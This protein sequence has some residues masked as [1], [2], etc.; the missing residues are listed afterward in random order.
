MKAEKKWRTIIRWLRDARISLGLFTFSVAVLVLAIF[1]VA[2]SIE[3]LMADYSAMASAQS[4]IGALATTRNAVEARGNALR[5]Y[6]ITGNENLLVDYRNTGSDSIASLANLKGLV[7]GDIA[8]TNRTEALQRTLAMQSAVME[9]I[10]DAYQHRRVEHVRQLLIEDDTKLRTLDHARRAIL[11]FDMAEHATLST[12]TARSNATLRS[13]ILAGTMGL[14]LYFLV[15]CTVFARMDKESEGRRGADSL[16]V[17]TNTELE[18]SL[19]QLK[20]HNHVAQ[21]VSQFGEILQ[22]C[23]SVGEATALTLHQVVHFLP[24]TSVDIGLFNESRDGV[25]VFRCRD[26]GDADQKFDVTTRITPHDC[27][28]LRRGR[29]HHYSKGGSDPRCDHVVEDATRSMC[30][31]ILG[32]GET[33]GIMSLYVR[34]TKEPVA[35][36]WDIALKVAERLAPALANLKLQETLRNQSVRDQLTQLFNR[37]YLDESLAREISRA[38]R[39]DLPV[40]VIMLD[41]DHF[42]QFNDTHGHDG[43]DLVLKSLGELLARSVRAEDIACRYGGEEFTLVLPGASHELALRRAEEVRAAVQRM[44]IAPKKADSVHITAS[45]GV[46]T[47][48]IHGAA[49]DEVLAAADA[50]LYLAKNSGRNRV[51]GAVSSDV[52]R[53]RVVA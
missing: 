49:I 35:V 39:Q 50:A 8:A 4:V 19:A 17:K 16:L 24:D 36:D 2:L 46:A 30:I 21:A 42:K 25:E 31:P 34:Q 3:N 23:R 32:Q 10:L 11:A 38:R 53:T 45:L 1:Y 22:N 15:Q 48:P 51:V 52:L 9:R 18:S 7:S 41:V 43:G 26:A 6:V 14:V 37:R 5:S 44:V 27:W 28:G 47:Y 33:L 12:A 13:A 29:V 20:Q 40:S